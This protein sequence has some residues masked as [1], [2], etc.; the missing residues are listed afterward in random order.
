MTSAISSHSHPPLYAEPTLKSAPAPPLPLPCLEAGGNGGE[1]ER[2]REESEDRHQRTSEEGNNNTK[3]NALPSSL[4]I[5]TPSSLPFPI[6]STLAT[7]GMAAKFGYGYTSIHGTTGSSSNSVYQQSQQ[8]QQKGPITYL[9]HA[10]TP[11]IAPNSVLFSPAGLPPRHQPALDSY[12]L[13]SGD[14]FTLISPS[15]TVQ[16]LPQ[17]QQ[18][19]RQPLQSNVDSSYPSSLSYPSMIEPTDVLLHSS[20]SSL[21]ARPKL[22]HLAPLSN[23]AGGIH[24]QQHL[25]SHSQGCT[26]PF[27]LSAPAQHQPSNLSSSMTMNGYTGQQST[28]QSSPS[29]THNRGSSTSSFTSTS[30]LLSTDSLM[31]SPTGSPTSSS[32]SQASSFQPSD[33][34]M[35]QNT[36]D[37]KP[38]PAPPAYTYGNQQQQQE[39]YPP[40]ELYPSSSYGLIQPNTTMNLQGP[41]LSSSSPASMQLTLQ[42]EPNFLLQPLQDVNSTHSNRSSISP[43]QMSFSPHISDNLTVAV[44]PSDIGDGIT[45]TQSN[46]NQQQQQQQQ[47]Q[48]LVAP[49]PR[50]PSLMRRQLDNDSV[51]VY[52]DDEANN[53]SGPE[54]TVA[55]ALDRSVQAREHLYHYSNDDGSSGQLQ[56]GRT[57]RRGRSGKNDSLCSISSM[58]PNLHYNPYQQ[59]ATPLASLPPMHAPSIVLPS[60]IK[61]LGTLP[62]DEAFSA[63]LDQLDDVP[64]GTK[65]PYLWWTLNRAAILGAPEQKLQME[66]LT[67]L[68]QQKYP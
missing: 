1:S 43:V 18:Q 4:F 15:G 29:H 34:F 67:Q 25:Q 6:S 10:D 50:A 13:P 63:S 54:E 27:S 20:T 61:S 21:S 35:L 40:K 45:P 47:Q 42:P 9:M 38:S 58:D 51:S 60:K 36:I 65:P 16:S 49:T 28:Y 39:F 26:G 33:S 53:Q 12:T 19:Q 14:Y 24:Q 66:T 11:P 68:I 32:Y 2:E 17:Q 56:I 55:S 57:L 31:W 52:S 64:P 23:P 62:A 44:S 7:P 22:S 3:T 48:T 8:P 41:Y 37:R 59:Q 30:S 46:F 5:N